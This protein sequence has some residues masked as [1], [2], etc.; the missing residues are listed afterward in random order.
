MTVARSVPSPRTV[1]PRRCGFNF[2]LKPTSTP[3]ESV[4]QCATSPATEPGGNGL[5][6]RGSP[7]CCAILSLTGAPSAAVHAESGHRSQSRSRPAA[8]A[9]PRR[10]PGRAVVEE[11]L[12]SDAKAAPGP[13]RGGALGVGQLEIVGAAL[14]RVAERLVS[15]VRAL[16]AFDRG[17]ALARSWRSAQASGW[18][19]IAILRYAFLMTSAVAP[20]GTPRAV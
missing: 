2:G 9:S 18:S 5:T 3:I 11:R 16:E 15:E 7:L 4:V 19:F 12:A 8:R 10:R 14:R 6:V 17:L 13:R 1:Q 20:R